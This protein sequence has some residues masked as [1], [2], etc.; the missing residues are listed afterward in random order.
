MMSRCQI[1]GNSSARD[2][3]GLTLQSIT[4]IVTA[5][6]DRFHGQRQQRQQQLRGRRRPGDQFPA[7]AR[8][9]G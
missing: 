1:L 6:R 4:A 5:N 9:P 8:A 3:G 7:V 2:G